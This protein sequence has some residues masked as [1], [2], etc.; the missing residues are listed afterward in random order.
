MSTT[1]SPKPM[2]IPTGQERYRW[3]KEHPSMRKQCLCLQCL[4]SRISSPTPGCN[5]C[6]MCPPVC[7]D[8]P[9]LHLPLTTTLAHPPPILQHLSSPT[10]HSGP[11]PCACDHLWGRNSN[12][13]GRD[14][15]RGGMGQKVGLL[16]LHCSYSAAFCSQCYCK[17]FPPSPQGSWGCPPLHSIL[18]HLSSAE[19]SCPGEKILQIKNSQSTSLDI[20]PC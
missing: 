13:Q 17:V 15:W 16:H 19:A 18:S 2:K 12:R 10:H 14:P 3:E 6:P 4:L 11:H 8:C 20:I 1:L 5:T 7:D 9:I